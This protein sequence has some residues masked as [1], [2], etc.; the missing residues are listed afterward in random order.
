MF[1]YTISSQV[2]PIL[3]WEGSG[4]KERQETN[5]VVLI[6]EAEGLGKQCHDQ[7]IEFM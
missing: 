1:L 6:K 7:V 2:E 3:N 4:G 5:Q